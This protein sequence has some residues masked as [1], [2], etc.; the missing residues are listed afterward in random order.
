[1]PLEPMFG[2]VLAVGGVALSDDRRSGN[3]LR[4]TCK[5][6]V[7][8]EAVP[9]GDLMADDVLLTDEGEAG[10]EDAVTVREVGDLALRE[11]R[12]DLDTESP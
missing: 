2:V 6:F 10:A 7:I 3:F 5:Y 11:N 4:S 1:M 12:V 9:S 8:V